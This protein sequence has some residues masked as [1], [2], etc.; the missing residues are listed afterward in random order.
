[1]ETKKFLIILLLFTFEL[2]HTNQS[3]DV[4]GIIQVFAIFTFK[5]KCYSIA[6]FVQIELIS[7]SKVIFNQNI[8]Y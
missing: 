6:F 7:T 4:M 1:M 5:V 8:L 3:L 2:T